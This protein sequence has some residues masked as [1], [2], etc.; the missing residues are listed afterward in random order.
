[1]K[2]IIWDAD[3]TLWEGE[4]VNGNVILKPETKEVL[5]QIDKLGITQVICSKNDELPLLDKLKEFDIGKYFKG[6]KASW[7]PKSKMVK[8]LL[9]A[10]MI[11]PLETLFIDDDKV[12]R[13]EVEMIIG[14]HTDFDEDLYNIFKYFDT[15]RLVTM[16]QQRTRETAEKNWRGDFKDFLKSLNMVVTI[17]RAEPENVSRIA[18]LANRTNEL[19]ASRMRY[20]EDDIKKF[21]D[22]DNYDVFVAFLKDVYGDYGLIGE[23]ILQRMT[24]YIFIKDFCVS[25]RTMGR[26]I[27]S[28]MLNYI[29]K[30]TKERGIPKIQ[31]YIRPSNDNWRMT[32]LYKK[33]GFE[34]VES[35]IE[36]GDYYELELKNYKFYDGTN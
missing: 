34:L 33:F 7:N 3:N 16:V 17:K 28:K 13:K 8:E 31:G 10:F 32:D 9:D 6:I 4:I 36:A 12:N 27:G 20:K 24:G 2:L 14:C 22:D 18:N 19:N 1:M 30:D 23:V 15:E 25:C 21:M 35:D 5:K 29:I 11:D 26:G